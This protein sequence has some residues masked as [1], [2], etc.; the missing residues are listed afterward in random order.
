MPQPCVLA[1]AEPSVYAGYLIKDNGLTLD[2]DANEGNL[3]GVTDFRHDFTLQGILL[4]VSV[5][6]TLS[7]GMGM[8]LSA[9]HVFPFEE[10]SRE[11][12]NQGQASRNWSTDQQWWYVQGAGTYAVH[13]FVSLVGGF[14][15]DSWMCNFADPE[16]PVVIATS[17]P[18]D[19]ADVTFSGYIPFGGIVFHK[20]PD[21]SGHSYMGG[22]IGFPVLW[23]S[24]DYNQTFGALAERISGDGEITEGHFLEAFAEYSIHMGN[25]SVGAFGRYTS[26]YGRDSSLTLKALSG[27]FGPQDF[28][29]KFDRRHWAF[30]AKASVSFTTPL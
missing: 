7:T 4:E 13:P 11:I 12:Y 26:L 27:T 3:G 10:R 5:P 20:P 15:W 21:C 30:G 24:W 22:V 18:E 19:R 16:D 9:G 25:L 29:F 2:F 8:M 6:V 17:T 23:A 1:A 28:S 14:R